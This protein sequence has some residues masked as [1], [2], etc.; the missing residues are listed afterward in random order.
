MTQILVKHFNSMYDKIVLFNICLS[1]S[2]H[3]DALI[4]VSQSDH[5]LSLHY[6]TKIAHA[7][8][9]AFLSSKIE[10]VIG[11]ILIFLIFLLKTKIVGTR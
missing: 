9:I 2:N 6:E 3:S 11:N 8:Y 4:H 1:H 10:N 5:P 7:I